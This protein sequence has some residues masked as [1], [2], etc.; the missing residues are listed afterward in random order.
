MLNMLVIDD[1]IYF[2]KIVVNSISTLNPDL[3]LCALVT[4]GEEAINVINTQKIDL[5][6]LDLNLPIYNGIDILEYLMTN[7]KNI[8]FNS[9]IV[10]S[11][12]AEMLLKI[13]NNPFVYSYIQK[14]SGIE[15]ILKEI[16]QLAS[17]KKSELKKEDTNKQKR[18][19]IKQQIYKELLCIGYNNKYAGTKYLSD[20]I[21]LQYFINNRKSIK[22][23]NDIY[24]IISQKYNVTINTIKC[25][26]IMATN[27]ANK[28]ISK[29]H[30][31][32]YFGFFLDK[33]I[34]PKLV[35]NTVLNKIKHKI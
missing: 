24:P 23:K 13:R 28:D 29:N 1:N 21:Y 3:R 15:N 34:T 30:I 27:K 35:I 26:I 2:A 31:Q 19:L 25:D 5:I 14:S 17:F 16:N 12:E 32:N 11:G 22:L 4:D 7:N 6:L 33:K 10:I 18:Q 9:I 8:Y 20:S